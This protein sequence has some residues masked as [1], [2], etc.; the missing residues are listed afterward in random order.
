MTPTLDTAVLLVF[1]NR[2]ETT[3]AVFEAVRK[4]R[5]TRLYCASDGPRNE[6]EAK[7]VIAIREHILA[8]IDWDCEVKTRFQ[9]S[10]LGCGQGV[11][12][13]IDW[14]FETEED[15]IILEDDV[16]PEE[17]FFYFCQELLERYRDDYRI[18]MIS[19]NN[20]CEY[21]LEHDSY[22]FSMHKSTWG[23]ATWRRAWAN[24]D[25]ALSWY[26]GRDQASII[27]NMG[28][29]AHS[30]RY[31][32]DILDE[33]EASYVDAWDYQWFFSLAAQNQLSVVPRKNLVANIGFGPDATHTFGVARAAFTK[34]WP[35]SFPLTHP[36]YVVPNIGFEKM[37]D[38][39]LKKNIWK[40]YIPLK[41]KTFIKK[42]LRIK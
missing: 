6:E 1:F 41:L 23:W 30:Y 16:V 27:S 4:V 38:M 8:N 19:G 33:I 42:R 11:K 28:H 21:T 35:L 25:I 9:E 26:D 17:S 5:P 14:M 36:E 31:W 29:S 20:H 37:M 7:R 40:T 15:G 22:L 10:N 32:K 12:S 3:K 34:S 24:M 2:P 13:A 18:G 39:E